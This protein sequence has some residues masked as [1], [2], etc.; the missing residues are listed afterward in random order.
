MGV[1]LKSKAGN[2]VSAPVPKKPRQLYSRSFEAAQSPLAHPKDRCFFA[3]GVCAEA[4]F[5]ADGF[6]AK[7]TVRSSRLQRLSSHFSR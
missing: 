6:F 7:M 2:V 3:S 4:I 1:M 5:V